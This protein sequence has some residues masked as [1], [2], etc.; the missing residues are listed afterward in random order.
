MCHKK[1]RS[2][3]EVRRVPRG[4]QHAPSLEAFN[5]NPCIFQETDPTEN[6]VSVDNVSHLHVA[7]ASKLSQKQNCHKNTQEHKDEQSSNHLACPRK[8]SLPLESIKSE[9]TTAPF[10]C[11]NIFRKAVFPL[12][13]IVIFVTC[14]N[15]LPPPPP[16][17]PHEWHRNEIHPWRASRGYNPPENQ[18]YKGEVAQ[19]VALRANAPSIMGGMWHFPN[20]PALVGLI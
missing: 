4:R 16:P 2:Q 11:H 10:G 9:S 1:T 3:N 6:T 8:V 5:A 19:K 7:H 15:S 17:P 14:H 20:M 13:P 12:W 18:G